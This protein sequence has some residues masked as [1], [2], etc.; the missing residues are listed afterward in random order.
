MKK[1]LSICYLFLL[2]VLLVDCNKKQDTEVYLVPQGFTGRV[3]VIYDRKD[4]VRPRIVGDSYV[5][6]IPSNG[7]LL[8]QLPFNKDMLK[9]K[10]F[11]M[12]VQGA[13]HAL[14]I[15]DRSRSNDSNHISTV[16][17]DSVLYV[18]GDGTAGIYGNS[19][20][21]RSVKWREFIV[22]RYDDI[23]KVEPLDSFIKRVKKIIGHDF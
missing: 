1:V 23:R 6:D 9:L 15:F 13:K 2:S 3:N 20:D 21:P 8:A 4:G 14:K 22:S 5:Y 17:A 7:I 10:Y 11:S 18:F 16:R 19:N 12:D